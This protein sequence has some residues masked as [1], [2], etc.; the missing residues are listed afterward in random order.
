MLLWMVLLL[1]VSMTEAQEL[2]QDPVLSRLNSSETSDLLLKCTTK[3]DP[4]KPASELFYSFYKDNHI[5]QNRS[6]NPLFFISEANEENSGLY[7]CVV[8]AKDGTIQ[9]K[10]DYLDI[11]LC[12]SVSQPVLTLQHE[13]TN[14]A[15]GDKVKFLCETQLGSLPILYSFYMDGEILG[16]PLA[17]S[18]R[19]AS[20]LIS[21][22]AEWSGKNYSCQAENKVSRDISEPKKFPLVVSGTASMKSTTVVIWLPVSCLVG[23]P[24]LLRF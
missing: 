3:V 12:T 21:V 4:N 1:C 7:Q 23:W 19:A 18:G 2:F 15:E 13:A 10:S 14:L 6:H 11:D 5:I 20:L 9:K 16:E 8:D 24:W 22:K 17:P